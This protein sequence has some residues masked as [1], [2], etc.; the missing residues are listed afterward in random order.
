LENLFAIPRNIN[1]KAS[2][3]KPQEHG[4]SDPS[5]RITAKSFHWSTY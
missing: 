4:Y 3:P 1:R 2:N 5:E